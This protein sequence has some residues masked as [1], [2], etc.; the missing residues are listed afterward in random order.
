MKSSKINGIKLFVFFSLCTLLCASISFAA[1]PKIDLDSFFIVPHHV[2]YFTVDK[3]ANRKAAKTISYM[4]DKNLSNQ[5]ME[6]LFDGGVI[7]GP[8]LWNRIERYP[9]VKNFDVDLIPMSAP[10]YQEGVLVKYKVFFAHLIRQKDWSFFKQVFRKELLNDEFKIVR[11]LTTEELREVWSMSDWAIQE[12]I[13]IAEGDNERILVNFNKQG[14]LFFIEDFSDL[15]LKNIIGKECP[16]TEFGNCQRR[17]VEQF[18]AVDVKSAAVIKHEDAPAKMVEPL[19]EA[20][21]TPNDEAALKP[22]EPI[23]KAALSDEPQEIVPDI[24]EELVKSKDIVEEQVVEKENVIKVPEPVKEEAK[25]P[26]VEKKEAAPEVR[27][28]TPQQPREKS[29]PK[30]PSSGPSFDMILT[31][32]DA[33]IISDPDN[34]GLYLKRSFVYLKTNSLAKAHADLNRAIELDPNNGEAYGLRAV[35]YGGMR[36]VDAALKDVE[37]AKELGYPIS[38]AFVDQLKK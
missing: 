17:L 6:A 24:E 21:E 33:M 23:K 1:Q 25:A 2:V 31:K 38:Q 10:V 12:P 19:P 4:L 20:K 28:A 22:V 36:Q 16:L 8:Y 27:I 37:K 3:E 7:C 35:F 29:P 18:T 30:K 9:I 32:L 11:K 14:K 5:I 34:P 13:L 15:N 26:V